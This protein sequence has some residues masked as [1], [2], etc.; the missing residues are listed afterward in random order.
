M[1]ARH[2]R[3]NLLRLIAL[4]I[5]SLA[6]SPVLANSSPFGV[7]GIDES[8]LKI[9][10]FGF[11]LDGIRGVGLGVQMLTPREGDDSAYSVAVRL[12]QLQSILGKDDGSLGWALGVS[13]LVG[14][15]LDERFRVDARLET[16]VAIGLRVATIFPV[17]G[18]G[19]ERLGPISDAYPNGVPFGPYGLVG[20]KA[21]V[22]IAHGFGV[23]AMFHYHI[24]ETEF[25]HFSFETRF[26]IGR[27]SPFFLGASYERFP[28]SSALAT[29]LGLAW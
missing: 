25:S 13:G 4:L 14:L 7:E 10:Y 19:V 5:M 26:L 6:A 12:D 17:V 28:E 16:G 3:T 15:D 20:L 24:R 27:G 22:G 29:S 2:H 8:D 23:D 18:V 1:K 9:H 11:P 21:R